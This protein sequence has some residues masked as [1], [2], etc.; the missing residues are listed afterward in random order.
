MSKKSKKGNNKRISSE[1]KTCFAF[2]AGF[3]V[4]GILLYLFGKF[5]YHSRDMVS[6]DDIKTAQTATVISV[7]LVERNLSQDE[8][9]I[10]K[11]KGYTEDEIDYK[12]EV[13]TA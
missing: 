5:G 2:T 3:L 10:E 12:Y 4:I 1:S 11:D 9:K 6:L 8:R 7:D 13:S